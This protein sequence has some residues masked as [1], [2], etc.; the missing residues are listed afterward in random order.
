MAHR[1][2]LRPATGFLAALLRDGRGATA[3][4]Y[5]LILALIVLGLM[6]G[7]MALGGQNQTSWGTLNN[8]VKAV[9]PQ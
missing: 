2:K 5:G 9:S 3:V 6:A 1:P 4:E 8:K 7:L